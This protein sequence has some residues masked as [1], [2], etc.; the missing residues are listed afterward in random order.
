MTPANRSSG[1]SVGAL[2]STPK[3]QRVFEQAQRTFQGTVPTADSVNRL[4]LLIEQLGSEDLGLKRPPASSPPDDGDAASASAHEPPHT[5]G[6]PTQVP[7]PAGGMHH[8]DPPT[9]AIAWMDIYENEHFEVKLFIIPPGHGLPIH[10]HP[11]MLVISKVLFGTLSVR[12]FHILDDPRAGPNRP[13][14]AVFK[15]TDSHLCG[16]HQ[17]QPFSADIGR[18]RPAACT[19]DGWV[20]GSGDTMP[21]GAPEVVCRTDD[22]RKARQLFPTTRLVLPGRDNVHEFVAVTTCAVLDVMGPP[23]ADQQGRECRYYHVETDKSVVTADEG[24]APDADVYLRESAQPS[25]YR[26]V[27]IPYTGPPLFTGRSR[28]AQV[29]THHHA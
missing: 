1:R 22:D 28:G 4:R 20:A 16:F 9:T 15:V 21:A 27:D 18:H 29:H 23:Y 14:S 8:Q 2:S 5:S 6:A 24:G 11:G 13:E 10:D 19:F 17:P 26:T 12:A 7:T 25:S 3:I